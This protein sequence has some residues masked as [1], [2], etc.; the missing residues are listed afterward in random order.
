MVVSQSRQQVSRAFKKTVA[1]FRELVRKRENT[2][3]AETEEAKKMGTIGY[4]ANISS[5]TKYSVARCISPESFSISALVPINS[6][7]TMKTF[8]ELLEVF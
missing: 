6:F 8:L 5:Q 3:K 2:C 1:D 4:I 7:V